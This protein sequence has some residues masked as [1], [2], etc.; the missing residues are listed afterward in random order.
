MALIFDSR[1][2]AKIVNIDHLA[3][4]SRP[5]LILLEEELVDAVANMDRSMVEV[6]S[7]KQQRGEKYD[8]NWDRK[9]KRKQTVCKV[10]IEKIQSIVSNSTNSE[11]REA[12]ERELQKLIEQELGLDLLTEFKKEAA[13]NAAKTLAKNFIS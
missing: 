4:L 8:E 5:E 2:L 6:K 7:E 9:V 13:K 1:S 12:Y 10:F 3:S 11:F